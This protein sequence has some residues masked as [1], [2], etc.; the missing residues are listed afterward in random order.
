[1]VPYCVMG[2]P[3]GLLLVEYPLVP[4]VFVW[5]IS[6]STFCLF[7]MDCDAA[8]KVPVMVGGAWYVLPSWDKDGLLCVV[9]TEDDGQ[10]SV[11]DPPLFSINLWLIGG[12]PWI[13]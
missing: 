9:S 3:L 8:D 10:L 4:L 13:P 11:I 6:L 5:K 12:E 7:R 1:M 2:Q